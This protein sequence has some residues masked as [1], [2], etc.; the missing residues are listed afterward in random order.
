MPLLFRSSAL[1]DE[2]LWDRLCLGEGE[3]LELDD[4]VETMLFGDRVRLFA[5]AGLGPGEAVLFF[6]GERGLG[7]V[8]GLAPV[9]GALP[10]LLI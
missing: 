8:E 7:E 2:S 10:L 1:A 6:D 5:D 3:R 9:G 4:R